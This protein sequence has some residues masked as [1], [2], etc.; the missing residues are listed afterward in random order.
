M[1]FIYWYTSYPICYAAGKIYE[2]P[3]E[4]QRE[5]IAQQVKSKWRLIGIRLR[6]DQPEIE[7]ITHKYSG[8]ESLCCS[9]LFRKWAAQ[10]VSTSCPFTWKGVI[11][12]LD[13]GFVNESSLARQLESMHMVQ[14]ML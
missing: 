10:D 2:V 6:L 5:F 3:T 12:T 8:D 13:N 1:Y 4:E 11:K 9:E 14:Y 7:Q